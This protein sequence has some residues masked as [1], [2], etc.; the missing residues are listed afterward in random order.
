MGI[1][2]SV[3]LFRD[4][5]VLRRVENALRSKEQ[6]LKAAAA[7]LR[8]QT[9]RM[10]TILNS[11]SDSVVVADGRGMIT[12]MNEAA[13]RIGGWPPNAMADGKWLQDY[14][15]LLGDGVTPI[16]DSELPLPRTIRG[17]Q[18]NDMEMV[19]RHVKSA[20]KV[21]VSANGRPL[22]DESKLVQGGV[23]VFRD[24]T[25]RVLS[26]QAMAEAFAQGRQ[27]VVDTVLHNIGN[28]LNSVSVGVGSIAAELR[29]NDVLRRFV[30]LARAAEAHRDDWLRYL[31][32]DPQGRQVLPFLLA[33]AAD[34]TAQ[35]EGMMKIVERVRARVTHIADIIRLEKPL[36]ASTQASKLVDLPR[37]VNAAVGFLADSLQSSGIDVS[38]DCDCGD[39]AAEV[40]IQENR[41]HQLLINLLKNAKEAIDERA[42]R[43]GLDAPRIRVRCHLQAGYL[44]LDVTDNGIGLD[45]DV[46]A[47]R[48]FSAG[49]T[50]KAGGSGLGLHSAA[51][52][53]IAA[54]G[55][56]HPRSDGIGKGTT[57][58]VMLPHGADSTARVEDS[59]EN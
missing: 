25:E 52:F 37:A 21:Y 49:Y 32:A 23:V 14:E 1:G 2:G 5:T 53:I 43:G 15:F 26:S 41:F 31:D 20:R 27:E 38:V 51:N 36:A 50:T 29:K 56:I 24:V 34:F 40:W 57:M 47:M 55:K 33:L 46:N 8:L 45:A 9:H 16:P 18:V 4:I 12:F 28:A 6:E 19:V 48:I 59:G 13:K 35:H 42:A 22:R 58:R 17:E 39:T 10:E 54:G 11:I 3:I 30:A 7:R 44:V